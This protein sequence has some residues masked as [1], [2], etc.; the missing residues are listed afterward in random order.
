MSLGDSLSDDTIL[1]ERA[2]ALVPLLDAE[3]EYADNEGKLSSAAVAALHRDG[4]LKLWVPEKLGGAELDPVHSLEV[5]ENLS[6]ADASAGWVT[7]AANLSIGTAG[8]YLSDH[9]VAELWGDGK[10]PVIAGQGTRPGTAKMVDGGLLLSGSWSFGSGLKHSSHVHSLG[11]VEETGEP[12]IFVTPIEAVNL[13]DNWDVMGLCGTGSIDYTMESV[14]VP[15]GW[16]HF[17]V[18]TTPERGGSLYGLG[19]IGFAVTCHSGWA[20][21]VGR[22]LLDELAELV[23]G[24]AGRP[25]AQADSVAFQQGYAE[26]EAKFRAARALVMESWTDLSKSLYAG[27]GISVRQHTLVRLALAHITKTLHEVA[28]FVYLAGGTTSLRRGTIQR[29]FRDVHAGTQHV[30]S[31]PNVWQTCGRE[32]MG[33]AEGK[34]WQFLDLVDPH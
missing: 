8:A 9:A 27:D 7:M 11:I 28:S 34:T 10:Q 13:I 30:T 4:L 25:G 16:S 26:A 1:A 18:T 23:H 29:M 21:G 20:M 12:R 5:L 24:K 3:A 2:K 15:N 14:F 19:I 6:Y 32:L 22:R 31:S 33:V 17:A